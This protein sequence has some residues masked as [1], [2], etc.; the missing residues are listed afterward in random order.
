MS[1]LTSANGYRLLEMFEKAK[2]DLSMALVRVPAD[3]SHLPCWVSG[4]DKAEAA[5]SEARKELCAFIGEFTS[6]PPEMPWDLG[7]FGVRD[8][9]D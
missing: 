4:I 7:K 9:H 5:L 1:E 3:A 8:D 2:D 6:F